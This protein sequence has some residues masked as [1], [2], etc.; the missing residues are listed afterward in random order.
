MP[1]TTAALIDRIGDHLV[2]TLPTTPDGVLTMQR[3]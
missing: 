2:A 3:Q 1:L